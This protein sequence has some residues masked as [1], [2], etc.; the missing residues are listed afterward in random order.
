MGG[1]EGGRIEEPDATVL[2]LD[3]S[4]HPVPAFSVGDR[5]NGY[6]VDGERA[7]TLTGHTDFN[8]APCWVTLTTVPLQ[9][10]GTA[11]AD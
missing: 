2:I 8:A 5:P 11:D 9:H 1:I 6:V 7:R 4:P 3:G 10:M